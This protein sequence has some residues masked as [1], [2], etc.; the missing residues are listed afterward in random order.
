MAREGG[1]HDLLVVCA[2]RSIIPKKHTHDVF[3]VP[4]CP[5][6]TDSD[7][8]KNDSAVV[9]AVVVAAAA[10]AIVVCCSVVV[11]GVFVVCNKSCFGLSKRDRVLPLGLYV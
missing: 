9:V 8:N 5:S 6:L 11:V 10:V 3:Y 7:V 2:L 1:T 4:E